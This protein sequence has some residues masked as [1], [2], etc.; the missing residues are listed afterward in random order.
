MYQTLLFLHFIGLALGVGTGF[1]QI[2]LGIANR[3]LSPEERGQFFR[4]TEALGKN[5]S[6]GL[7]LLIL[8]GLGM[9]FMRTWPAVLQW[10]G[11]AFHAKLTLVV[12]FIGV[13][14]YLQMLVRRARREGGGPA[15]ATIPKVSRVL[16]LMAIAIV[17]CAVIAFQ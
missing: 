11:P 14:G 7:A 1:A 10:G 15:L 5:G 9:S 3:N 8:T 12:L 13:F 2:T 17:L 6:I 16:L 4:R